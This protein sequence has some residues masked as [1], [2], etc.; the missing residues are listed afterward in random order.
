MEV[1]QR[2]RG[3]ISLPLAP[4]RRRAEEGGLLEGL[5]FLRR[6]GSGLVRRDQP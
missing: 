6:R 3:E 4:P 2:A 5:L 1:R